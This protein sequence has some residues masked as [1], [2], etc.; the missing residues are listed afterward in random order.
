MADRMAAA[1][2]AGDPNNPAIPH[3]PAYDL[4]AR[5]VMIF[6]DEM[7][8]ENDPRRPYRLLLWEKLQDG[9]A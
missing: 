6:D 7:R 2:V 4:Q 9:R 8:V 5:P 1:W 3:W